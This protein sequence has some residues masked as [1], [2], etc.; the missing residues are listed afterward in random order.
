MNQHQCNRKRYISHTDYRCRIVINKAK[1]ICQK[2]KNHQHYFLY[3]SFGSDHSNAIK[4]NDKAI[5]SKKIG[6]VLSS[7]ATESELI[8]I[9]SELYLHFG[10]THNKTLHNIDR[11][12]SCSD[13]AKRHVN[14]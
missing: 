7:L 13:R 11:K 3:N 8:Y 5:H 9:G 10:D 12:D 1:T 6:I 2:P 4:N 14:I